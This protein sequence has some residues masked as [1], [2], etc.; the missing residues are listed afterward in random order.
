MHLA[1]A[2]LRQVIQWPV[3]RFASAMQSGKSSFWHSE[4]WRNSE[5]SKPDSCAVGLMKTSQ[6]ISGLPVR[7]QLHLEM[8]AMPGKVKTAD[9]GAAGE[10]IPDFGKDWSR[11]TGAGEI[12]VTFSGRSSQYRFGSGMRA[13]HHPDGADTSCR[14]SASGRS[15]KKKNASVA[16]A[17]T[18]SAPTIGHGASPCCAC[19]PPASGRK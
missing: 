12:L 17:V 2:A 3:Q 11:G 9:S 7:N 4:V 1:T 19:P 15:E 18:S 14:A 10:N 6:S 13:L 5:K 8:A 16:R